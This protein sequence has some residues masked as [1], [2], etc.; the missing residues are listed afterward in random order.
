MTAA[1]NLNYNT[2]YNP[3]Q[4]QMQAANYNIRPIN[5][6]NIQNTQAQTAQNT[7][8]TKPAALSHIPYQQDVLSLSTKPSSGDV[9]NILNP[10][11]ENNQ[12]NSSL[13][14][15]MPAPDIQTPEINTE[16]Q[17]EIQNSDISD[18]NQEKP[19]PSL[20]VGVVDAPNNASLT[21]ITDNLNSRAAEIEQTVLPEIQKNNNS[22]VPTSL[23]KKPLN[24]GKLSAGL[25]FGSLG[26]IAA[27]LIPKGISKISKLIKHI[28]HK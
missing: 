6:Q 11:Q 19:L 26:V 21:P 20:N 12:T 25:M 28:K 13:Q 1:P 5:T 22:P 7:A 24:A 2:G 8:A 10:P 9:Q 3:Y 14:A 4:T 27:M 23:G 15:Q 17:G 16:T 18:K